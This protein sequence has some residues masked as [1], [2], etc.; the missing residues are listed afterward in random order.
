[1]S[2]RYAARR[3]PVRISLIVPA[4]NE[5]KL[6]SKWFAQF[7][8]EIKE[9][10]GIELILS[11]GGSRDRTMEIAKEFLTESDQIIHHTAPRKQ[12]IAEGRNRGAEAAH[13]D[14]LMFVNADTL[15]GLTESHV[16]RFFRAILRELQPPKVKALTM[17]VRVFPE[18]EMW[19]DVVFHTLNNFCFL[20]LNH[21]LG[22]GIVGVGRGE[23]H[24]VR[25]DVFFAERGYN[26]RMAAGED[27]DLYRRIGCRHIKFIPYLTIYES[28][29]RYRK[30]GYRAIAKE[31]FTNAVH[32]MM[33]GK[34]LSK[35]W[36]EVR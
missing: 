26:E 29:R 10:F 1:M 34:S 22:R 17:Y 25:R 12:T 33:H 11:D 16:A 9:R 4:L 6:I 27:F 14:I 24:V 18:E 35:E 8:P 19:K 7:P 3:K 32:V 20:Q 15:I 21:F 36:V 31:W 5:E 13:G 30:F 23:C 28:P 2:T